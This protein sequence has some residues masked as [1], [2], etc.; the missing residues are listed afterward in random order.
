MYKL[1]YDE[2]KGI[3]S[4]FD[5]WEETLIWSCLQGYMG[6]AWVND[7][8]NPI[9]AQI[10]TG[11]FCFYAGKPNTPLV[12]NIP[13][14][15]PS[16]CILMIPPN[17]EWSTLIEQEYGNKA[18]KFMRYAIKKEPDVFDKEKL[19][20]YKKGI[21]PEYRIVKIDE[22]VYKLLRSEEW[23]KDFCSLYPTF[24]DFNKKGL[25]FVV[26]HG[27]KIVSGASSY[28][29][30]KNGIEIEIDTREEYRRKRLALV[31]ASALILEC[32]EKGLYPS[33]DAANME[34]VALSEKLG[35]HFDHEYIT[36]AVSDIR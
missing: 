33:W 7:K 12:K 28:T 22:A 17:E 2:M 30:Y 1:N 20:N 21:S 13:E 36:Y 27:G 11:D 14:E 15:F 26:L 4:M 5:G 31:C 32:L 23:S 24:I 3:S 25:G 9:S 34:S 29:V 10:I 16:K 19:E 35:Y 8:E 6:D 18:Q